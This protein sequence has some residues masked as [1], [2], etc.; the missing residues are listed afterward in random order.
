MPL[1]AEL[2]F[3]MMCFNMPVFAENKK[4]TETLFIIS[5]LNMQFWRSDICEKPFY[6]I[7]T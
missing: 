5:L 4:E 3:L 7:S 1:C 2:K 6:G